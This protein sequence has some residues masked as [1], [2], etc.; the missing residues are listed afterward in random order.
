VSSAAV[1]AANPLDGSTRAFAYVTAE[2][3]PLYRAI[4]RVFI[5]AKERFVIHLSPHDVF[6]GL[7][8]AGFSEMPAR[9]ELDAALAR[10]CEWG[11]L[12]THSDTKNAKA[13]EDF[14]NPR[15]R[16]QIT[17][18]GEAAE[19]ALARYDENS[20]P[21][22]N[23]QCSG[24]ADIRFVLQELKQLSRQEEPDAGRVHRN[25]LALRALIEE[26]SATS[27]VFIGRM[28]RV[29]EL[30]LPDARRLIDYSRRFIAELELESVGIGEIIRDLE[31]SGFERLIRS[32]A[33]RSNREGMDSTPEAVELAC[34]QWRLYWKRFRSWFISQTGLP[35]NSERLRDHATASI[36]ALLRIVAGINDSRTH[37]VDRS[38]DFRLLARWFAQAG[39]DSE[40]HV[41]WRAAFGLYSARHLTINEATLAEREMQD[42]PANTS[43]LE[44]PPLRISNSFRDY[45]GASRTGGLT[46]I[47]DRSDA[48]EK[49][50]ETGIEEAQLLLNAQRRFGTGKRLRLS[51]LGQLETGEFELFLDLLGDAVSARVSPSEIVEVFSGDG[52]FRV[53]LEPTGDDPEA[54]ILTADGTFSGPDQWISIEQISI[55]ETPE[56]VM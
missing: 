32:M 48:K 4:M 45:R 36:P 12:K 41:L 9:P 23:L 30:Q 55:N 35:S 2:N 34:E 54:S 10:L 28:D 39:S 25:L 11:N 44:A 46:R 3:A 50:A 31:A 15:F 52:C 51:E 7:Q 17:T 29:I 24:L 33:E 37:R 43:W 53:K 19:S 13:V 56:V 27:Q 38:S 22:S 40:A 21:A 49:L 6:D 47:I 16:F 14:Y 1:H 8:L 5:E 18:Q 20:G 26:L 42:I